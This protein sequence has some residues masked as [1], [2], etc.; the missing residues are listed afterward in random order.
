MKFSQ[1]VSERRTIR[2]FEQRQVPDADLL[3]IVDDART[4]SCACNWQRLRYTI[5]RSPEVVEKLFAHTA[6]GG[7]VE[8]DA[9]IELIPYNEA[10]NYVKKGMARL[11]IF[12][13]IDHHD[14]NFF[15][16]L[17]NTLPQS[18]EEM[19]NY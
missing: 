18:F 16:E 19:P 2:F 13:R 7:K 5:V 4:A 17:P 6:Y 1:L 8:R 9:F 14:P 10:R 11:L 12:H 15:F 3:K